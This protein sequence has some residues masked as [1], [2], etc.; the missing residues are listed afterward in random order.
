MTAVTHVFFDIGGVLGTN[1][2]D[3]EQRAVA[4][5]RFGLDAEFEARHREVVGDWELGRLST[6]EY[7]DLVLF[8]EPRPFTRDAFFAWMLAQSQP[9]PETI[10]LAR[11]VAES[12]RVGLFTL[13]NE[14]AELNQ[15]RIDRFGLAGIFDAFLSS[16]WLG[17]R[18]PL[19]RIFD[20][21]LSVVQAPA[22]AALLIDDREQNLAPARALGMRTILYRGTAPLEQA[23]QREGLL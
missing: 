11:R 22:G 18:K 1:G 7:L 16:C 8:Y 14:S 20:V 9:F 15:A 2:W 19:R 23:L 13:N 12:G 10:A 5:E 21:A 4:A 6:D 3:S 17:T